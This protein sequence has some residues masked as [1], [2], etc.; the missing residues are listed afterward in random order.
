MKKKRKNLNKETKL[1]C[2][3]YFDCDNQSFYFEKGREI[4]N[5]I[6]ERQI[7]LSKMD[8]ILKLFN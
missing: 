5:F 7:N 1:L 6:G 3:C 8:Q 2:V 4:K